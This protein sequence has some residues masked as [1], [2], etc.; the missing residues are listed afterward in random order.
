MPEVRTL[1]PPLGPLRGMD[2]DKGGGGWGRYHLRIWP[3]RWVVVGPE[4]ADEA[5]NTCGR[6]GAVRSRFHLPDWP[7]F[8]TRN[9]LS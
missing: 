8:L 4:N 9:L 6:G 1:H 7:L 2:K 5:D 3:H